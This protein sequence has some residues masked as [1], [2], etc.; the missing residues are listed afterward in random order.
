MGFC[1]DCSLSGRFEDCVCQGGS[2]VCGVK[3][4]GCLGLPVGEP[5]TAKA[6]TDSLP[7]AKNGN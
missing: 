2:V 5:G 6:K 4:L 3:P 1:L 7:A